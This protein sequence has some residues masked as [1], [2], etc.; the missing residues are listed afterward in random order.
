MRKG[1]ISKV[2]PPLFLAS[3]FILSFIACHKE[4]EVKQAGNETGKVNQKAN[5]HYPRELLLKQPD[6]TA[7]EIVSEFEPARGGYSLA[8]KFAK[9]GEYYRRE[10]DIMVDFDKF[11]QPTIR[12]WRPARIFVP[13]SK[14]NTP[15]KW[16][17]HAANPEIFA[18]TEGISFEDAGA[19]VVNGRECLKV[20]A[21]KQGAAPTSEEAKEVVILYVAK[22]LQ[23]LVIKTEI[24]LVDR[25]RTSFLR[26]ISFDVPD[27]LFK[28]LARYKPSNS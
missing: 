26:N 4:R 6:F 5:D 18:K 16:Y 7:E 17:E 21:T 14:D 23:N 10:S 8:I 25:K 12:Y 3:L 22:D 20:K 2:R 1:F 27:E 28:V 11:G 13:P 24:S 9:K 19:E 15:P